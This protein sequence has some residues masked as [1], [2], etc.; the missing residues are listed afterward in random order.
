VVFLQPKGPKVRDG[1]TYEP[2]NSVWL[3]EGYRQG[4][5]GRASRD[6]GGN[7]ENAGILQGESP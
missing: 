6:A 5:C 4:P 7:E 2:G 1:A 3:L